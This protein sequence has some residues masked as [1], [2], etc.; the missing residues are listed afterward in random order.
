M[1]SFTAADVKAL[2]E[3]TGAGMLDCKKALQDANGS[4]AEA[5]KILKEKGLAAMAKR[6]DR[7]TGEGRI[8]IDEDLARKLFASGQVF[9]QYVDENG[10]PG[11]DIDVNPNGSVWAIEG[12]TSPDGRILGKM[13][14]SERIADGLYKNV[15]GRY[16]MKLFQ[17]AK[18]YFSL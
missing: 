8:V 2:R 13:G 11:M 18:A 17:S 7:A 6:S 3:A 4:V 15:D 10:V 12:I 1:A 5:E 16:D 9:T 14:H